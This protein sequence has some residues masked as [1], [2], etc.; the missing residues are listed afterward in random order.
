MKKYVEAELEIINLTSADIITGSGDV[1]DP[2]DPDNEVP[3]GGN[4]PWP[5]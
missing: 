1:S 4:T 2:V 3:A 5:V